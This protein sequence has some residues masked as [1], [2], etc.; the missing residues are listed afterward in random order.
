MYFLL[1]MGIFHCYVSLPEGTNFGGINMLIFAGT[2][3]WRGEGGSQLEMPSTN[4]CATRAT[5]PNDPLGTPDPSLFW[6]LPAFQANTSYVELLGFC[7]N[8]IWFPIKG[9]MFV[10]IMTAKMWWFDFWLTFELFGSN[11]DQ[12]LKKRGLTGCHVRYWP[13]N[14]RWI[15]MFPVQKKT[16]RKTKGLQGNKTDFLL[17]KEFPSPRK[18]F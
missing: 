18:Q 6:K 10:N 8:F 16:P 14:G 5:S 11:L 15:K 12:G 7:R 3:L 2:F 1:N 9:L 4:L 17:L 13:G